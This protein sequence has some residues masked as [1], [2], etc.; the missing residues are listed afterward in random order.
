MGEADAQRKI[1]EMEGRRKLFQ[2]EAS[3]KAEESGGKRKGT[4]EPSRPLNELCAGGFYERE[5]VVAAQDIT[6]KSKLVVRQ[7]TRGQVVG[8]SEND[9][10]CR[11]AVSFVKRE[12]GAEANLNVVPKE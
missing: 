7:G 9:P 5:V 10:V 12:D 8:P 6:V 4:E 1:V 11:I 3:R 2:T